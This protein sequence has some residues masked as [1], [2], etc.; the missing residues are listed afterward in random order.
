MDDK[1]ADSSAP[2]AEQEVSETEKDAADLSQMSDCSE[3]VCIPRILIF[4]HSVTTLF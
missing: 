3:K 1:A 4:S 2:E